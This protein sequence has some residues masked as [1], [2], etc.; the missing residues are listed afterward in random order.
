MTLAA[1]ILTG[2]SAAAPRAGGKSSPAGGGGRD[3][4]RESADTLTSCER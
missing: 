4:G 2:S 1:R 3:R